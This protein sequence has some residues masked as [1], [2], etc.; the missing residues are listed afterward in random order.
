MHP[1][2]TNCAISLYH[3][4]HDSHLRKHIKYLLSFSRS[5]LNCEQD[6]MKFTNQIRKFSREVGGNNKILSCARKY[7]NHLLSLM[8]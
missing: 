3:I 1:L 5:C 7:S 6:G 4:L 8:H 2:D